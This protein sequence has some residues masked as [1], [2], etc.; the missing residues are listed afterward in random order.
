[1]V[2]L[3]H[4]LVPLFLG[5][6]ASPGF[7]LAQ[8]DRETGTPSLVVAHVE[9]ELGVGTLALV[10]RAAERARR[11]N[12][13]LVLDLETPG[14][15]VD[16]MWK[17]VAELDEA[18][19]SGVTTTAWIHDH[20]LSAGALVALSCQHVYGTPLGSIGSALPVRVGVGGLVP[21]AEDDAVEEKLSSALRAEFRGIANERGRPGLV[22]EAMVDPNVEVRQVRVEGEILL[23]SNKEWNDLRERGDDVELIKTIC[24]K[25]ELLNVTTREGVQLGLVDGVAE[26]LDELAQKIGVDTSNVLH[27]EVSRSEELSS[28]LYGIGPLL[29]IL[30]GLFVFLELKMPGF[31]VPGVLAA[32]CFGLALFGR[33]LVGLADAP[34]LVLFVVGV[35]GLA[36]EF[37]VMPGALWPGIAGGLA[38]LVAAGWSLLGTGVG[39]EYGLEQRILVDELFALL[40]MALSVMGGAWILSRFLPNTSIYDR[41]AVAPTAGAGG[42]SGA[43]PQAELERKVAAGARGRALTA[44][45]PV[46]KIRLDRFGVH[47][48]EAL[49]PGGSILPGKSVRVDEVQRSGRLVVSAVPDDDELS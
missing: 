8:A 38:L 28:L 11:A 29:L 45:R 14:G 36:V 16:L 44:L 10:H 7:A 1:M 6:L 49:S 20:A 12:V 3:L 42:T 46:G 41:L 5:F 47:E 4:A 33:Y 18:L 37:F 40:L 25:G 21:A 30:G 17:L 27:L 34:H 48:F 23:V 43:L 39:L 24:A 22:A 2:K 13:P 15:R 9:G 26:D 32:L 31:G 19:A 35:V